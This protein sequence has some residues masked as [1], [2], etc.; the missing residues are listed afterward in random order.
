MCHPK[1]LFY[2]H[3]TRRHGVPRCRVPGPSYTVTKFKLRFKTYRQS[4]LF[5]SGDIFLQ[6]A[7]VFNFSRALFK[8]F[9]HHVELNSCLF[10]IC[11]L[12]FSSGATCWFYMPLSASLHTSN[13]WPTSIPFH[14]H[15]ECIIKFSILHRMSKNITSHMSRRGKKQSSWKLNSFSCFCK[16]LSK[17]HGPLSSGNTRRQK[18]VLESVNP[19]TFYFSQ[20]FRK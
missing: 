18:K 13:C 9:A 3:T 10:I 8:F 20:F 2:G 5:I 15:L 14:S 7:R 11:F 17:V 19:S 6:I 16:S 12:P 1:R 4:L